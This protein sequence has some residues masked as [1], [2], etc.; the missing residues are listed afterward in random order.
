MRNILKDNQIK[1]QTLFPA[2][3]KVK[4]AEGIRIYDTAKEASE[5]MTKRGFQ[6]K[7]IKSSESILEQLKQLTW[8]RVSRVTRSDTSH[9]A[10]DPGY[11]KKLRAFKRSTATPTEH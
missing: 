10:P 4:Y 1:F 11:R 7:V 2:R 9:P 8:S 6:V 3:L 5:D